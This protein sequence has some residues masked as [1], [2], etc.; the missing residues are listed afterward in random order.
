MR[1][2]PIVMH[3]PLPQNSPQVLFAPRDHPVQALAPHASDQSF[4]V[5]IGVGR[6]LHLNVT[7]KDDVFASLILIIPGTGKSLN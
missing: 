7:A 2:S 1:A 4:T 3:N 6:R 5:G